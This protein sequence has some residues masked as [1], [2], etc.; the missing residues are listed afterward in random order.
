MPIK[1]IDKISI[2][3]PCYNASKTID[4]CL[5]S[6]INQT[7]NNM[8]II[9]INDNS[10]D[11]TLEKLKTYK[12]IIIINNK[13]NIGPAASRNKGLDKASGKYIGFVDADDY[14]DKTMYETM[15][16]Y[17]KKDVDMIACSRINI[18]KKGNTE[19]I[20]KDQIINSHNFS[21]T[22]NYIWDKLF[23]KEIIDEYKIRFND[24]YS[25]AEDFDFLLKYKYYSK[26]KIRIINKPLYFYNADSDNSITNSYQDNLMHIIDVQKEEISFFKKE[27][28]FDKYYNELLTMST[29]FYVRRVREFKKYNNKELQKRFVDEFLNF[30]EYNFKDDYKKSINHFTGKNMFFRSSKKLMHIYIDVLNLRRK[31]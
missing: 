16:S 26:G 5:N 1:S 3:I 29:A 13:K 27:N 23:K 4:K 20:H 30:F 28:M 17:I 21:K 15:V 14:V 10:K 22:S 24:K 11:N 2:I 31:K 25:Y 6:L 12:N 8:E 7:Y 19:I 9:C 18:T